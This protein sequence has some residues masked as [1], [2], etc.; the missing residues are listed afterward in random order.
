MIG[1]GIS[2]QDS[3]AEEEQ[4]TYSN[5]HSWSRSNGGPAFRGLDL[6]QDVRMRTHSV[7][8]TQKRSKNPYN[9]MCDSRLHRYNPKMLTD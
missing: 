4:G 6:S 8:K 9:R 7:I 5:L 3:E 2:K 1:Y